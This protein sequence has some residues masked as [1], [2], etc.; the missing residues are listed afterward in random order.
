MLRKLIMFS[1]VCVF[2][3]GCSKVTYANYDRVEMGMIKSDVEMIL[4]KADNCEAVIGTHSCIWGNEE[5][6]YIKVSFI[7]D[8]AA[9]ITQKGLK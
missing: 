5:D 8:R 2:L 9:V 3:A 4:G 6:K 7:M 1:I